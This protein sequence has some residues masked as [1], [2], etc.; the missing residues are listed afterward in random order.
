MLLLLLLFAT[1]SYVLSRVA[2]SDHS[3]RRR[4]I[5]VISESSSGRSIAVADSYMWL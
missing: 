3:R 2:C 5:P 4:H 1:N